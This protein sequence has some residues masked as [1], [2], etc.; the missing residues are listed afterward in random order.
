MEKYG[1]VEGTILMNWVLVRII[2][3][4]MMLGRVQRR[5]TRRNRKLSMKLKRHLIRFLHRVMRKR[6]QLLLWSCKVLNHP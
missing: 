4:R 6:S 3:L 2:Q 1:D 5:F